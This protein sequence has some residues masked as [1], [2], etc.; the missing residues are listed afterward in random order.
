MSHHHEPTAA[1]TRAGNEN[2][3]RTGDR[4]SHDFAAHPNRDIAVRIA[5]NDL[6]RI[7]AEPSRRSHRRFTIA[8]CIEA[9]WP[10]V[11]IERSIGRRR[12]HHW[13]RLAQGAI[14]EKRQ[15]A[16]NML[17]RR[18]GIGSDYE[19]TLEIKPG[20]PCPYEPLR[21]V[22]PSLLFETASIVARDQHQRG[23]EKT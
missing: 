21:I 15:L 6:E 10:E 4:I 14:R 5:K 18:F 20:I 11:H 23:K 1:T 9:E 3:P 12:F 7:G 22:C 17:L 16:L 19:R 13:I 2:S 8:P